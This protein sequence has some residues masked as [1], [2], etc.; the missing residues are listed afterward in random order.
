MT[1]LKPKDKYQVVLGT[2]EMSP[3]LSVLYLPILGAPAFSLYDYFLAQGR[4]LTEKKSH[5]FLLSALDCGLPDFLKSRQKLEALG[6]MKTFYTEDTYYYQLK[7]PLSVEKFFQDDIF[8]QLLREKIGDTALN[9]LKEKLLPEKIS[10]KDISVTFTTI[11]PRTLDYLPTEST[12]KK[13]KESN[14]TFDWL[15][16]SDILSH[17]GIHLREFSKED[18]K[19]L[20]D[21]VN[22]YGYSELDL[23]KLTLRSTVT[24]LEGEVFS[25]KKLKQIIAKE[26]SEKLQDLNDIKPVTQNEDR[27]AL[28]LEKGFTQEEI[29]FIKACEEFTPLNFLA[30]IKKQKGGFVA[31]SEK[32]LIENLHKRHVLPDSVLNV[33]LDYVL[34]QQNRSNLQSAYVE[35]IANSWAQEKIY[36]PEEAILKTRKRQQGTGTPKN[37]R[38]NTGNVKKETLPEWVDQPVEETQMTD[39]E[40]AAFQKRINKLKESR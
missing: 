11:F 31:N 18:R 25:L 3:L 38:K 34:R 5:T 39:E 14:T 1:S 36:T 32:Y 17:Q 8:I 28:L 7:N 23:G 21:I 13:V 2:Y 6:L 15:F 22:L 4:I 30:G 20:Q 33:L 35:A 40:K 27:F 24:S 16:F 37:P 19:E 10:G 9:E 26:F 29:A 12:P